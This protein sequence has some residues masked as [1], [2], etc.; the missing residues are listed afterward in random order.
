MK[1]E[2]CEFCH[3]TGETEEGQFDDYAFK[4]C[5]CQIEE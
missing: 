5:I 3:D 1:K 4:K 2:I